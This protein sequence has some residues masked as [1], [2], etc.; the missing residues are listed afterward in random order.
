MGD[1]VAS[2]MVKT[3]YPLGMHSRT[4]RDC[5]ELT[6]RQG[7]DSFLVLAPTT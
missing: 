3:A 7:R 5:S 6:T 2:V 1:I 4:F